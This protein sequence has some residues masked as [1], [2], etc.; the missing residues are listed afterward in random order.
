MLLTM[1]LESKF[2]QYEILERQ[3]EAILEY[4]FSVGWILPLLW[5]LFV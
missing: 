4:Q 1:V 5:T 3:I 2:K